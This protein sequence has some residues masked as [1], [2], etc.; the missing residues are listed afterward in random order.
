M[1]TKES[2]F[3]SLLVLVVWVVIH[4]PLGLLHHHEPVCE[5]ECISPLSDS[6]FHEDSEPDCLFCINLFSQFYC[7]IQNFRQQYFLIAAVDLQLI[8]SL[9]LDN[10]F[11]LLTSRGPPGC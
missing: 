7:D 1:K 9:W 2:K 8:N 5:H 4:L 10:K 6:H 11:I 3:F